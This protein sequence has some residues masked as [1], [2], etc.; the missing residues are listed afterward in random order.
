[1]NRSGAV[2]KIWIAVGFAT[3]W[4]LIV[5]LRTDIPIQRDDYPLGIGQ[6]DEKRAE[7]QADGLS[8]EKTARQQFRSHRHTNA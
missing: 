5:H 7:V 1:M 4:D 3:L 2:S 8:S 6:L